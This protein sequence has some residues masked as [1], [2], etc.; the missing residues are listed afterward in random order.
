MITD[1]QG[2]QAAF[3]ARRILKGAHSC[4]S[5]TLNTPWDFDTRFPLT[6]LRDAHIVVV[7]LIGSRT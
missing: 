1:I 3:W 7:G 2:L 6:R 5:N 4:E